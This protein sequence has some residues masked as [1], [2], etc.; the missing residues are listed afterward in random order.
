MFVSTRGLYQHVKILERVFRPSQ[1]PIRWN[2]DINGSAG[3]QDLP[4]EDLEKPSNSIGAK[5]IETSVS[6]FTIYAH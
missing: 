6:S 4:L 5:I 3:R 1:R 2:V